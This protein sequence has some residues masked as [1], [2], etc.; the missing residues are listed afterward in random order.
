MDHGCSVTFADIHPLQS[1]G[2]WPHSAIASFGYLPGR[3]LAATASKN[4]GGR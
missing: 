2:R 3:V 4:F 1:V